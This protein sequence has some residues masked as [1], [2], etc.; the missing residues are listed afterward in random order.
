MGNAVQPRGQPRLTRIEISRSLPEHNH[1]ILSDVLREA[2]VI[3]HA[4]RIHL[5]RRQVPH[6]EVRISTLVTLAN[7]GN[8]VSF[9]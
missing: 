9:I 7:K 1:H 5:Y 2:V 8:Q 6:H 3:N 4:F